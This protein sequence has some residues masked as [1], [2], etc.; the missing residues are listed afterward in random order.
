MAKMLQPPLPARLCIY[1]RAEEKTIELMQTV[2]RSGLFWDRAVEG[3]TARTFTVIC[4]FPE[5]P[6]FW[7]IMSA[8]NLL[9]D[10]FLIMDALRIAIRP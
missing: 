6:G 8:S 2:V 9:R 5:I 4:L 3:R 7:D 1:I 10:S